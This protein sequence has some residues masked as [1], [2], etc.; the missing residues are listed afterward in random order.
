MIFKILLLTS[1]LMVI[2]MVLKHHRD[3]INN[4]C[5]ERPAISFTTVRALPY[6]P[7]GVL[8]VVY[9]ECEEAPPER[10]V[11]FSGRIYVKG[12]DIIS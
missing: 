11:P 9:S 3:M 10:G 8:P 2:V 1:T 12:W 7:W 5:S 6:Y 4:R